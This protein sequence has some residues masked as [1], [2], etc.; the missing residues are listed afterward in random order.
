MGPLCL[1]LIAGSGDVVS[2]KATAD[3]VLPA[4]IFLACCSLVAGIAFTLFRVEMHG[5]PLTLRRA[6]EADVARR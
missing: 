5:R 6:P 2:P 1:A 3:A 4:F